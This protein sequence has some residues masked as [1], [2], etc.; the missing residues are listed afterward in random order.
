MTALH[1]LDQLAGARPD[2]PAL[3]DEA[4]TVSYRRLWR[5]LTGVAGALRT[6]G[7]RH[8]D[9]VVV[10][11]DR[12]WQGIVSMLGVLRAGAAYVPVDA[13]DPVDRLRHVV[14]TAG[15][16]WAT[17]RAEA[18]AA[19]P[20]LGLHPVP[21]GSAPAPDSAPDSAPASGSGSGGVGGLPG[22][23]DLAYVMFT[24]G[25]TGTAKAVMVPHRSI[26]HAAPS[27]ARRCGITPD[28]RFLSWASLVWD[29]SGE[30]LYSTL[31]SGAGL[32]LDREATSG[33]V[34]ALLRAVER[35][36]VSVVDLP[37]AFWN[38]VVDY[39]E[40]TG[41]AVPECLRLVVVG[42]EEVRARQVRVWAR[43]APEIRLLNTY[44]QTETV[45]VTHAADIGGLAP[46]DGGA[47]PIGHPLPHVRQHLEPVG[48][49]LFELHVGG[50]TLAWGYRDRPAATAE[51]FLP[52]ERGRRFRTGDLVRVADD[53]ALVFVGRADRQ[54]K[55]RGVRVEPAEVERALMACP[56]VTAAAAFVV[57]NASDG[58]LLVG[59]FVPGDAGTTPAT[60]AAAL[61]ARLSPALLPHRLVSVPSMPL[62]TTGKIDQAAL[63]ERFARSDVAPGAGLAGQLAVVFSEVLG[64]PCAADD[65]FFDQGGDSVVAT[66]LLTRI[67]RSYRVELTFRDVFDHPSP[68]ALAGLISRTPR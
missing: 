52:D 56:G 58:V 67:R 25:S 28:D 11:A 57:D 53:G 1:R 2:A 13:G 22:P 9:R 46:P 65:D 30:E 47:V 3:L 8:G 48:D 39:L 40:T 35:R 19:L 23:E 6:A 41:E 64:T 55:V 4:E 18:L 26:A 59:A 33:S 63:V 21:F 36:S 54:V 60:V 66:R 32:V 20:D 27:L 17:G 38:Q 12:T 49:G 61:R 29:T 42:G 24:S 10:P 43:R 50:P 5:E 62:L 7:V 31:L 16:A 37:T 45:M 34:P 68:T 51:R 14:R 44:G 15:A